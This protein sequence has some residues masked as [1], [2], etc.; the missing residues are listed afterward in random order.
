MALTPHL[1]I[2]LL[3]ASQAQKELTANEAFK[4]LEILQN[5]AALSMGSNT[6]PT[7][8]AAYECHIVGTSPSGSWA[9]QAQAFAYYDGIWQFITPRLGMRV[10]VE[11]TGLCSFDGT[12]WQVVT[13]LA[14]VFYSAIQGVPTSTNG[15]AALATIS[16][17]AGKPDISTLNFD[18]SSAESTSFCIACPQGQYSQ[19]ALTL[20]WSATSTGNARWQASALALEDADLFSSFGATSSITSSANANNLHITQAL[21]L[22]LSTSGM[23]LLHITRDAAHAD[24]TL[25]TDA[26]L[27]G[28]G[29]RFIL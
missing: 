12:K 2:A 8:P 26:R 28:V 5:C 11:N 23:L 29:V 20:Y 21:T 13:T 16:T 17:G 6:P 9:A 24:D 25:S 18:A 10:W 1:G 14:P 27:H 22:T 7:S 4:R 3:E 19:I 15:C